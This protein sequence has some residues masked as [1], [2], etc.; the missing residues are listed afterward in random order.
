MVSRRPRY[1]RSR[2]ERSGDLRADGGIRGSPRQAG[3]EPGH[4]HH[5]WP[6][7]P[8]VGVQANLLRQVAREEK[9]R[10]RRESPA[11]AAIAGQAP[12]DKSQS[13]CLR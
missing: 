6:S 5:P 9:R 11:S 7:P 13:L 8:K 2:G 12:R 4:Q 10:R 1:G 3:G